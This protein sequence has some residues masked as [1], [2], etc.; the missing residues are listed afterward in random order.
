MCFQTIMNS[1]ITKDETIK[2]SPVYIG[3]LILKVLKTKKDDKATIF[4]VTEH[5][6]RELKVIHYRQ[7]VL[8]LVFLHTAGVINFTEPYIYRI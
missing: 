1:L 7:I 3:Y 5:L 4:D 6:K 8:S 2:T